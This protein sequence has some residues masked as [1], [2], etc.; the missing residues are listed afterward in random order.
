MAHGGRTTEQV[1]GFSSPLPVY[2]GGWL[3]LQAWQQAYPLSH[4]TGP[5]EYFV[6]HFY[7]CVKLVYNL[8][9]FLWPTWYVKNTGFLKGSLVMFLPTLFHGG[10]R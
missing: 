10:M 1:V 5:S 9:V 4:P 8:C 7:S 6:R 3:G 2:M